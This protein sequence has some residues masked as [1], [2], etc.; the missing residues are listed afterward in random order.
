MDEALSQ[1]GEASGPLS[2]SFNCTHFGYS[3]DAWKL[4]FESRG[5]EVAAYLDPNTRMVDFLMPADLWQRF[6]ESEVRVRAVSMVPISEGSIDSIGR[7]LDAVSTPTAAALRDY[8]L[9][10]GLF[11]WRGLVESGGD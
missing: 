9:E 5:V 4:A 7:Y 8:R 2:V 11:E 3:L 6:P 1:L 10:P